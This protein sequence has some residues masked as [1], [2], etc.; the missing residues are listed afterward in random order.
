M[1][2]DI[3]VYSVAESEFTARR[4]RSEQI[5]N[6]SA[7]SFEMRGEFYA[8]EDIRRLFLIDAYFRIE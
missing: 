3:G 5:N 2:R 8:I 6:V 7:A 4:S 1:G